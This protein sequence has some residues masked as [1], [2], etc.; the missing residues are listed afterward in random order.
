MKTLYIHHCF[1]IPTAALLRGGAIFAS[2]G[3]VT[4]SHCAFAHNYAVLD[5]G[6]CNVRHGAQLTVTSS[7]FVGSASGGSGGSIAACGGSIEQCVFEGTSS[8]LHLLQI[9]NNL[10]ILSIRCAPR[11]DAVGA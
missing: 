8:I 11:A 3:T 2:A 4:I 1:L 10:L 6:D 7:T 5:G 9:I